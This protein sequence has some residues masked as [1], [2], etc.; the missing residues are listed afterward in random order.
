MELIRVKDEAEMSLQL[1]NT[2][3]GKFDMRRERQRMD[4]LHRF[5]LAEKKKRF[6]G[7]GKK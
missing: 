4:V 5:R 7:Y 3:C 2:L 6:A 1:F